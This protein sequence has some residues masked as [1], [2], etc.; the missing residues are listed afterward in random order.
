MRD[1]QLPGPDKHLYTIEGVCKELDLNRTTLNRLIAEGKFPRGRK[2]AGRTQWTGADIAA[3]LL[4]ADRWFPDE[5]GTTR[6]P[7]E[8]SRKKRKK[9]SDEDS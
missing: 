7:E 4:L 2:I 1:W 6:E 8:E 5:P 9:A 3:Y